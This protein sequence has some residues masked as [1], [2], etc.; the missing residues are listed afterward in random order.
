[1]KKLFALMIICLCA[2]MSNA[3]EVNLKFKDPTVDKG[4]VVSNEKFILLSW[5]GWGRASRDC[6]GWGLCHAHGFYCT[7]D[8]VPVNC[9]GSSK[10]VAGAT[11]QQE[12]ETGNYYMLI[13]L[14][15][16]MP[17]EQSDEYN[18]LPVDKDISVKVVDEKDEKELTILAGEYSFDEKLGT[19]GGYKVS[20]K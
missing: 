1:M 20:I 5:D 13:L 7:H 9:F 12:E 18:T 2:L 3:Q 17:K 19:N 11:L 4:T 6:A 15:E 8:N 10:V 14:N 16:P